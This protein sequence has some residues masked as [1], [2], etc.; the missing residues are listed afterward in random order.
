MLELLF[1]PG[2]GYQCFGM[3]MGGTSRGKDAK[4][5]SEV[6]KGG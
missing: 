6:G 4:S 3:D 5:P 2:G 1:Q